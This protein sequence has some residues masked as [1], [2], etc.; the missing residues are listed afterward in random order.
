MSAAA[1]PAHV[2]KPASGRLESILTLIVVAI[3][4]LGCVNYALSKAKQHPEPKLMQW[5]ISA[6]G[7]L[8]PVDQAIHSSLLAAADEIAENY[9]FTSRWK[10]V[11]DLEEGLN[12]PFYKD[13]FWEQNG[14]VK[15]TRYAPPVEDTSGGV[16]YMGTLGQAKGQGAY[17]LVM[18]HVHA[19][20]ATAQQNTVWIHPKNNPPVPAVVKPETLILQGWRQVIAYSGADE[21]RKTRGS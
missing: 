5:Q 20:I 6:L 19:G 2:V 12:P 9:L 15:W 3:I 17:L 14:K 7:G 13:S 1:L 4:T 11:K 18:A 21:A 10:D 8:N 16:Y